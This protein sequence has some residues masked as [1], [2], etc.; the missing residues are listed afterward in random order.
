MNSGSSKLLCQVLRSQTHMWPWEQKTSLY[1][2]NVVEFNY[3]IIGFK[4]SF[5]FC[6]CSG[7]STAEFLGQKTHA[8]CQQLLSIVETAR[9]FSGSQPEC[10]SC[11]SLA[12]TYR[13]LQSPDLH[14]STWKGEEIYLSHG[15]VEPGGVGTVEI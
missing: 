14:I 12:V 4:S 7:I 8:L 6:L 10:C 11:L 2:P 15:I 1:K 9:V 13:P 5:T 3:W